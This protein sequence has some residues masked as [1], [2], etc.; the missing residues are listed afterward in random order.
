MSIILGGKGLW[1][2]RRGLFSKPFKA[3]KI[4]VFPCKIDFKKGGQSLNSAKLFT[5][6]RRSKNRGLW[7][8][9][10]ILFP[11]IIKDL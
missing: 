11:L 8:Q 9:K 10:Q 7:K 1:S 6:R 4:E 2:M 5:K 3:I